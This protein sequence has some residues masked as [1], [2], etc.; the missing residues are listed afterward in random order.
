MAHSVACLLSVVL[1][2]VSCRKPNSE[3]GVT[4]RSAVQ[5]KP[6]PPMQT[7]TFD[8]PQATSFSAPYASSLRN[9]QVLVRRRRL[10]QLVRHS[11][12]NAG[13]PTP[14]LAPFSL[15]VSPNGAHGVLT[16][17][18]GNDVVAGGR[19]DWPANQGDVVAFDDRVF[20]RGT[21]MTWQGEPMAR[22]ANVS[23]TAQV[24]RID[25][26]RYAALFDG[27]RGPGDY[28]FAATFNL[29][30]GP[31]SLDDLTPRWAAGGNGRGIGAIGADFSSVIYFESGALQ[32]V[33]L[34]DSI[35]NQVALAGERKLDV[36]AKHVSIIPPLIMLVARD[37]A[38]SKL[39][40]FTGDTTPV[41]SLTVPF[42][43]LQPAVAG[44]G[45]RVYLAGK[46]LAALDDGK[47]TWTHESSEPLYVSSFEDGS[48][49]VANGK[50]L[51]F[52]KPDGTVDQSFPTE[53]PLV[54]PP[55]IAA[56]GSVWAASATALYI[57]R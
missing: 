46:G 10:E 42:E 3:P 26:R 1:L 19:V 12:P 8:G 23:V 33:A 32:V 50:R 29:M 55:A 22:E 18:S 35:K 4:A 39:L 5:A 44:A 28:L 43:V 9:S 54:A 51:D 53:E 40:A 48:L 41:Y 20:V 47:F 6:Q 38:G 25:P 15:V 30:G 21:P 49:A 2:L 11:L 7:P 17:L 45:K 37:G 52:L 13:A 27:L 16:S 14:R 31:R 36:V 34:T 57:A 56:D 24:R